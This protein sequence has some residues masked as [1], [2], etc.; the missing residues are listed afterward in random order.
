MGVDSRVDKQQEDWLLRG[1]VVRAGWQ[2]VLNRRVVRHELGRKLVLCDMLSILGWEVVARL[3]GGAL[4]LL[5]AEV[6]DA[7]WVQDSTARLALDGS[8]AYKLHIFNLFERRV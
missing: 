8:V 4:P 1:W 2:H 6:N 3:A 5:V 7:I